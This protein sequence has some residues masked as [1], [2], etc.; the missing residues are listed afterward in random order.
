MEDLIREA[1]ED[2]DGRKKMSK[3]NSKSL[4][5]LRQKLRKY[6]NSHFDIEVKKFREDP[7]DDDLEDPA[8]EEKKEDDFDEDDLD[9]SNSRLT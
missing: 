9:R 4:S 8:A 7:D 3:S 2:A 5:A 1:W 6:I